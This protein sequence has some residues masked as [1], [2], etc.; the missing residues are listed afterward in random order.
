MGDT[1]PFAT[2]FFYTALAATLFAYGVVVVDAY[3]RLSLASDHEGARTQVVL[4]PSSPARFEDAANQPW[5]RKVHPF[6]AG[7]LALIVMRLAYLGWHIGGRRF[8]V[9]V[10]VLVSLSSLVLRDVPLPTLMA[11]LWTQLLQVIGAIAI[12]V[13]LWWLVLREQRF[14]RSV[15]VDSRELRAL[16]LR[17]LVATALIVTATALGGWSS[18]NAVG[19]PCV[20]FPTCQDLWWPPMDLIDAFSFT[21]LS[22]TVGVGGAIT[23]PAATAMHMMH[24]LVSLIALLYAG[25]LAMRVFWTGAEHNL[26]RYGLMVLALLICDVGLGIMTVVTGIPV[27]TLLAHATVAALLLLSMITLYHVTLPRYR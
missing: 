9:P 8:F 1:S 21:R 11:Q 27:V 26:C 10:A 20:E 5:Q 18:I 19:L 14:W 12:L 3:S 23:A 15:V 16:R 22:D 2:R 24:R 25:W 17:V 7:A 13:L 6:L 4:Q